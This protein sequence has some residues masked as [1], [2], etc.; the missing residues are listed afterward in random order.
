MTAGGVVAEATPALRGTAAHRHTNLEILRIA[1]AFGIVGYHAQVPAK[2]VPYAGLIVFLALSPLVDAR[3]NWAKIRSMTSLAKVFLLPWAFWF[4]V[5][6]AANLVMHKPVLPEGN[7]V[8]SVLYGSAP[9]LWFLP[10]IFIMLGVMGL[11]KR[12]CA[13]VVVFW[14]AT[15]MASLVLATSIGWRPI[16]INAA[17]PYTQWIHGAAAVLAGLALGLYRDTF[18]GAWVGIV[19]LGA[20]LLLCATYQLPGLSVTYAIGLVAVAVALFAVE[21]FNSHGK[22]IRAVS[23]CMFGV[24]LVHILAIAIVK[25][26]VP[27]DNYAMA[28][29][30]FAICLAGVALTRRILPQTK[31][32]LG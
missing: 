10:F 31:L 18:R 21:P 26:V 19:L 22:G 5:Y 8:G 27:V 2:E 20:A 16:T 7:S 4:I 9:H 17:V 32:V 13:P 28:L 23:Q 30:I 3:F 25:K 14:I 6:A 11:I 12:G 1:A 24:Y 15:A 29:A